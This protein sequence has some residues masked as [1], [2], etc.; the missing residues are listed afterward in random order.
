MSCSWRCT[1]LCR[2]PWPRSPGDRYDADLWLVDAKN[3]LIWLATGGAA[4]RRAL[5]RHVQSWGSRDHPGGP[6]VLLELCWSGQHTFTVPRCKLVDM[7]RWDHHSDVT[8][9]L[10]SVSQ[11]TK[12]SHSPCK[13]FSP[14]PGVYLDELLPNHFHRGPP[15]V[16]AA[17]QG[18]VQEVWERPGQ[19][20]GEE[21]GKQEFHSKVLN[22]YSQLWLFLSSSHN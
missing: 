6:D 12:Y 8:F 20:R 4:P 15:G 16:P 11:F 22:L 9:R 7:I 3:A 18:G 19:T 2:R 21:R 14:I 1:T 13:I 5:P 10:P 17:G